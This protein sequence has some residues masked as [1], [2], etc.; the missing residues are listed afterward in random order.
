M[1]EKKW[2]NIEAGHVLE[3]LK[4]NEKQGLTNEEAAARQG[5]YGKN[6]LPVGK[7]E[8]KWKK[9]FK[10]FHDVLIYVLLAAALITVILGHYIDTVV[11]LLV[12]VIN[13]VIGYVQ[14]NKA[15]KALNGIR[16]MLSL[17]ANV[18]RGGLR[19]E[20]ASKELVPGDIVLL[21][22]GDKVPA[23]LRVLRADNLKVEESPLTGESVSVEK[24]IETLP[25]DTVLGDRKNMV[26]S[27]T[28]IASGSGLGV[29]VATGEQTEIGKINRSMTQ[30]EE[31]QTPL[32]KQTAKFGKMISVVILF[33]AAAMFL[34]GYIFHDY[35]ASE[36]LLAVIGLAVAAIPEGL[37]AILSII[38]ALGV[39]T[40][41]SNNA[42]VRNLPSVETLGAV[43]VICSDKTGTLTKN[44]MTV[45]SLILA[46]KEFDI[47]GTGYEPAG[48][49]EWNGQE[50][51]LETD[52]ALKDF[53]TCVKTVNEASLYQDEQG[54][55]VINGEPTESCLV[56]VAE[57]ANQPV[58][59]LESLSKIPFD[60]AYK[61][62]ASLVEVDGEK[63]IYVKGA[64]DRL[65]EMAGLEAGSSERTLWEEKMKK[66]AQ[67]GKR[68]IGAAMKKVSS[69]VTT[70]D[71]V[72]VQSGLTLL[73][74][75]GI[76][77]PPREEA[78][79]A[80]SE[81]KKA[82]IVVKMITGDHKETAIA[83]GNQ[84][85]IGDG[86]RAIE[87]RELDQMTP[88]QLKQAAVDYDVFARTSPEN[89]L[90]LVQAL[91]EHGHICAM[92]GDGVNDAPALKRADIGV[93]MGIK[94]TEVSKDAS[95]M[96]LVDDNFRTIVNAVREG[97]RVYDN[98]KK[99]ILFILP[100][101]GAE[102]FL[103]F[104]AILFGTMMPLTPVQILWVNMI[105]AVTISLAIAF[106]KLEKGTMERPP[107]EPDTKLLS[108]YYIF[109]IVFVSLLIG[110]G[111]LAM[112]AE[113]MNNG[114]DQA[115][116]NTVT[117]QALVIAQLFHLFNC[118]SERN[119]ALT[120][121]FFT[122]KI[123]FLVAG[124]LIFIQL[125]VTYLPFMNTVLGTAP[126]PADYW[127][128]PVLIG[129]A[130]FVIVEIEKWITRKVVAARA[131]R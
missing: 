14:E 92:T 124:L 87:G 41:A 29:V 95:Q 74:L 35:E 54:Q 2:Y 67:M 128:I 112:N 23:D 33:G 45:T 120:K 40:M 51:D 50:A 110:G 72:D 17:K 79:V 109:R 20:V 15:E 34:F 64:P 75:A 101:N 125:G 114:Y 66:Q 44:E 126:I 90:Q 31:L 104:A 80:V 103:I 22:A 130:V 38:L 21:R 131:S 94:G 83:I 84:L 85:G 55:W 59:K 121:D 117:L 61:Y 81:C 26:F 113:L 4:T 118:R 91:Q 42:I 8:P 11:I 32:L 119:F 100:T 12:A 77:D 39:Q 1:Q 28:A 60:S 111:I 48:Q 89:K 68:V 63:V 47:T 88:E 122:N 123:A 36:L 58:A 82:G 127:I 96:V 102:A 27:G 9:F 69:D 13:A 10:H 76:I 37:P 18:I 107:R 5:Q 24:R 106:E 78:I 46:E 30:V 115:M 86:T 65:F 73:G 52:A 105:T 93:A 16:N 43:S 49:I 25:E 97:R 98:L 70:I 7:V 6:E 108:P 99:T 129:F 62:M 57:K 71:H 56:T 3:Q 116:V 53:L 19:T